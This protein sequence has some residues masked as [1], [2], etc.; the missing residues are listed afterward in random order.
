MQRWNRLRDTANQQRLRQHRNLSRPGEDNHHESSDAHAG[1]SDSSVQPALQR[2]Y[3]LG[4]RG[5][6]FDIW[7]DLQGAYQRRQLAQHYRQLNVF[8]RIADGNAVHGVRLR[9]ELERR[10]KRHRQHQRRNR[11]LVPGRQLP[12]GRIGRDCQEQP[13]SASI[14]IRRD[15]DA[16]CAKSPI[17]M[18]SFLV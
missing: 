9:V 8:Q 13:Y 4:Q 18:R 14:T 5:V 10:Q 2:G 12:S 6:G 1:A 15:M 7:I 11:L 16:V 3:D 17:K